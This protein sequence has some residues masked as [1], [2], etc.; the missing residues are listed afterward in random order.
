MIGENK[1][2]KIE[3]KCGNLRKC[4]R[5]HNEIISHA[6]WFISIRDRARKN[7]FYQTKGVTC[8]LT[9]TCNKTEFNSG[10]THLSG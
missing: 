1:M 4:L 7:C 3:W 5:Q 2:T 9:R 8:T 6:M 10:D